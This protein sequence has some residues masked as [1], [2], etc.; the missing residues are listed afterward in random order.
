MAI[1]NVTKR[2]KVRIETGKSTTNV[3]RDGE[4]QANE[5][6]Q[7]PWEST[8]YRVAA[9]LESTNVRLYHGDASTIMEG[10]PE[11][12]IDCIITS[13]PYYGQ[14]DYGVQG[15][16]GLEEHPRQYLERLVTTFRAAHRLLK[17]R[18]SLWVIIGDTYWSGKG[19]PVGGDGKQRSRRFDRPQDR[20]GERPWCAPKQLLLIPHRF[21]I[22]MQDEG[23]IVRNDN[24]WVKSSPMPDPVSDRCAIAHEYVFHFVKQRHY[25]FDKSA[26][27]VPSLDGHRMKP[28][29]TVWTVPRDGTRK[30]HIAPFPVK[31]AELPIL[32]TCP[33][34]GWVLD[35]FC[36]SGTTL[37]CTLLLGERRKAIGI[38]I[39]E[40]A[41]DETRSRLGLEQPTV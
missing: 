13:P 34:N 15:Q 29:S 22:A 30:K 31:L 8:L 23:W 41:L 37:L 33:P 9:Y 19:K 40:E 10:L 38:D 16:I 27:A 20:A 14:R 32:S 12:S 28:P 21:A 4:R 1:A 7:N 24:I 26:V 35:P 2:A 18:G 11:S 36:G 17:Q 3:S 25:Y 39:S 6:K 5:H